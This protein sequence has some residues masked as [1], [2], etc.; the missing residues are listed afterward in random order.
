M[1]ASCVL[2]RT[3]LFFFFFLDQF[4]PGTNLRVWYITYQS[5]YTELFVIESMLTNE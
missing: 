5:H 4:D 1:K 3:N 2:A